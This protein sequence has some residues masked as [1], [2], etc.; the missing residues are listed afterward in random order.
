MAK[1][2]DQ[3]GLQLVLSKLTNKYDGRYLGL[4][5]TADAAQKTVHKLTINVRDEESRVF[6]GSADF[7]IDVA[8]AS[9]RHPASE[10]DFTH[11]GM[12][13]VANVNEALD[14][15]IKNVQ[16]A[17]GV[18]SSTTANMNTLKEALDQEVADRKQAITDEETAR[19]NADTGLDNR[20]KALEELLNG[21]GNVNEAILAVI[22]RLAAEEQRSLAKDTEHDNAIANHK[23]RLET[24][25]GDGE[26]SIKKAVKDEQDRAVAKENELSQA[27]AAEKSR[28]ELAEQGLADDLAEEVTARTNADTALSER[29]SANKGRLDVLE[30]DENTEGSIA[31]DIKDA[32]ARVKVV[33][34]ALDGRMTGAEGRLDTIQGTGEGSIKKAIADLV[35]GAPEQLDTLKEISEALRDNADVLDAIEEAFDTKLKAEK[36]AREA[37]EKLL[38]AEDARLDQAIKDEATAR[39]NAVKAE[40]SAR[41]AADNALDERILEIEGLIGDESMSLKDIREAIE[42]NQKAIQAEA[43]TRGEED[44]KIQTQLN[45]VDGDANT[46]GSFRKAIADQAATQLA[47]DTAQDARVKALEDKVGNDGGTAAD[48]TGL[49]ATLRGAIESEATTRKSEDDRLEGRIADIEELIGDGEGSTTLADLNERLTEAE[50]EI[51]KCQADILKNAQDIAAI[52]ALE[53]ADIDAAFNA[54]FQ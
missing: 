20:I 46:E 11:A 45:K 29:I 15:L 4:H 6:D 3:A 14:V 23:S 50:K 31:K 51:D 54:V 40:A 52:V 44:Q 35:N 33:T 32:E 21:S 27:I 17:S 22:E 5:A 7:S 30:A 10:V 48:S 47:K 16:I 34:D 41:E 36:D 39:D 26:G 12:S 43:K 2:L 53:E 18:L 49:V 25:E 24:I 38:D 9:H 37:K 1:Y 19:K 28:A 13:G 42:A 8:Q